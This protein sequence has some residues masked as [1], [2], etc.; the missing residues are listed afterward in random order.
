MTPY[1]CYMARRSRDYP[2]VSGPDLADPSYRAGKE[3]KARH[4]TQISTR[5][6]RPP[7]SEKRV[8]EWRVDRTRVARIQEC[9]GHQ[10]K[11]HHRT[12]RKRRSAWFLSEE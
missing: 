5:C 11:Q 7:S 1:G 9:V 6:N 8:S 2:S 12:A 3:L 4:Y 10:R